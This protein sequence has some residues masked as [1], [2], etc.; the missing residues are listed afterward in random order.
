MTHV[1]ITN[2]KPLTQARLRE[3][4]DYN[5]SDGLFR[6][7]ISVSNRKAGEIAGTLHKKGY[8]IIRVDSTMYKA[9]RLA[10]VYMTGAWPTG[11]VDHRNRIKTDNRWGNLRDVGPI[12][13][14]QN[15]S[16]P[17]A[18]NKTG[19]RG[20][21]WRARS[22]R[23]VAQI[24]INGRRATLGYFGRAE[25]AYAAYCAARSKHHPGFVPDE[26]CA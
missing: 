10:F 9:H 12:C 14:A 13:N 22:N 24:Q 6:R 1:S 3:L 7:R 11:E 26:V 2:A 23:F 21:C 4:F 8:T 16:K 17:R 25:D 5:P 15:H 18:D 20:V 19:M